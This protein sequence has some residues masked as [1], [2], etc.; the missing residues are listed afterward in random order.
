[1]NIILNGSTGLILFLI[2]NFKV[3]ENIQNCHQLQI[4]FDKL[5]HQIDTRITNYLENI[6]TEFMTSIIEYYDQIIETQEYSFSVR[7][8]TN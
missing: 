1:M 8:K 3:Y 5:T 2:S 4:K 6:N 7:I